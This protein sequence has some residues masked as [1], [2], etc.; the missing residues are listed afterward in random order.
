MKKLLV[1]FVILSNFLVGCN[2]MRLYMR[3]A[4][5][6][7]LLQTPGSSSPNQTSSPFISILVPVDA[8]YV[9]TT[10]AS[11]VQ[12]GG[13]C[14]ENGQAALI[15]VA[16]SSTLT[17]T[18]SCN[19][20]LWST[21]VDL[22]SL[23][24]GP[25]AI[26]A[27]HQ[28]NLGHSATTAL[29]QVIKDTAQSPAT[30][31]WIMNPASGSSSYLKTPSISGI[32]EGASTI[33]IYDGTSC[34]A[35]NLIATKVVAGS[36]NLNPNPLA[37]FTVQTSSLSEGL[38]SFSYS[39]TDIAGNMRACAST[40]L[41]YSV[42]VTP[43]AAPTSVALSVPTVS[44]GNNS[45]PTF[46]VTSAALPAGVAQVNLFNNPSCSGASVGSAIPVVGS[47]STSVQITNALSNAT[48]ATSYYAQFKDAA[49]NASTCA[50]S[51]S[52]QYDGLVP[53]AATGWLM[54]P[55]N[56]STSNV[57][58]PTLT[59]SAEGASTVQLFDDSSCLTSV[60][61]VV[62]SGAGDLNP[63]ANA[64]FT[65][66]TSVL[67][68]GVHGFYY[69]ITDI[70]GNSSSCLSTGLSYTL[71]TTG[72]SAPSSITLQ[73]PAISP[74][75]LSQ[76]VFRVNTAALA[77]N[78]SMVYLYRDATCAAGTSVGSAVAVAG[79]VTTNVQVAAALTDS[80]VSSNYYANLKDSAG[81]YSA[82]VGGAAYQ[83]DSKVPTAVT[84]WTMTPASGSTSN[85]A[86][87][88]ITGSGEGAA[89]VELFSN[90]SCTASL[91][92][93]VI[94]G[95]GDNNPNAFTTFSKT[96]SGLTTGNYAFFYKVT[97]VAG[98]VKSCASTGLSYSLNLVA[99]IAPTSPWIP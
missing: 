49:G 15:T 6:A 37:A 47:T 16:G 33:Q 57:A 36:G 24:D 91:G 81:N 85:V 27:D 28:D 68:D 79:S 46:V 72:P 53:V 35:A 74:N 97:D 87:P 59:A 94:S 67:A 83:Y 9:N 30:T 76:P 77:S 86:N 11:S 78:V 73:T 52:Y 54:V 66:V 84:N 98:N 8:S 58:T 96:L 17:S 39:I 55:A 38:H 92:S 34:S 93:V 45:K 29:S 80:T 61:S 10:N 99:P 65:K 70:A 63:N 69:K 50:G 14:S 18:V 71:N 82:C 5:D 22:S 2:Q 56:G 19:G 12:V 41:S 43:P 88:I 95:S 32:A 51:A 42:D 31:G 75:N 1:G 25:I 89:T 64:S 4:P 90:S 60:G 3:D 23:D 26:S 44:P 62:I 21:T 40:G 7:L 13:A 48:V 20:G